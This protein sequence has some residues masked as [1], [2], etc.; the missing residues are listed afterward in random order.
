M[1]EEK[2]KHIEIPESVLEQDFQSS[3][4]EDIVKNY[5]ILKTKQLVGFAYWLCNNSIDDFEIKWKIFN[6]MYDNDKSLT[7]EQLEQIG[8]IIL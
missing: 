8:K 7:K 3:I 2:I 4:I 6:A 1:E 5:D